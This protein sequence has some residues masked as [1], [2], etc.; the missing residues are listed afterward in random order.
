M[1][2]LEQGG[3]AAA[4]F[5]LLGV[6]GDSSSLILGNKSGLL[7]KYKLPGNCHWTN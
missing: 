7:L 1:G 6:L 5:G 2:G 3:L 4:L